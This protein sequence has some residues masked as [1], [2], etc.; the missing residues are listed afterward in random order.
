MCFGVRALAVRGPATSTASEVA[1]ALL[2]VDQVKASEDVKQLLK[3]EFA[4]AAAIVDEETRLRILLR[5]GQVQVRLGELAEAAGHGGQGVGDR[6][7]LG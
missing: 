1:P 6:Q 5:I 4:A 3:Q 7:D 2:I